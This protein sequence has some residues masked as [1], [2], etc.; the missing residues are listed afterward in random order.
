MENIKQTLIKHLGHLYDNK[1]WNF[2][3]CAYMSYDDAY[4]DT[5][6]INLVIDG[7]VEKFLD[8]L[9]FEID[10][11]RTDLHGIIW[12]ADGTWSRYCVDYDDCKGWWTRYVCPEIPK[13]LCKEGE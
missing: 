3:V 1:D 10:S 7:D 5:I 6:N 2:I 9:D 8:E 11:Y 13:Y 12:Y 4:S